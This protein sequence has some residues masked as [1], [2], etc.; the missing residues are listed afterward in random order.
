M[1]A[2]NEFRQ[3]LLFRINVIPIHLPPLRDRRED[4][5]LLINSFIH[6]L[7]QKTGKTITGVNHDAMEAFMEY[8]WPG[9]IRE[10]KNA[11]EYSFVTTEGS[12]ITPDHLPKKINFPSRATAAPRQEKPD[13]K[14][15]NILIE[16]N[17]GL[18]VLESW[19]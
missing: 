4:I 14:S 7:N 15:S 16:D 13:E 18:A 5:P 9:N 12:A 11:M 1:I 17:R 2:N 8:H 3:D 19:L 6:R 10:L